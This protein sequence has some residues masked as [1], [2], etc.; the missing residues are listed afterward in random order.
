MKKGVSF[1]PS[2]RGVQTGVMDDLKALSPH[3]K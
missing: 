1:F 2:E 3:L